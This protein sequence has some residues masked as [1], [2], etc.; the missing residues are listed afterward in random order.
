M[1]HLYGRFWTRADLSQ[2]VGQMEQIAGIRAL[3]SRDGT[4]RGVR[5]FE[6]FTGAGLT[7]RV[8]ADRALDISSCRF[9]DT[10]VAWSSPSG[11]VHPAYYEAD[12]LGWLRSFPGGLL[13]TCGLDH[14]GSPSSE[15]GE[16]FGIHGR[17]GNLPA[18]QVSYR[19]YWEGD[20]YI[21]EISG[22]VRQARLFGEFLTLQRRIRTQLGS[23]SIQ[24]DDEVIN[25]GFQSQ[26]HMILY[27]FNLGFPLISPQTELSIPAQETM[28]RDAEAESGFKDW[29]RLQPPTAGYREQVFRHTLNEGRVEIHN[30]ERNLRLTLTY[31]TATLP[32]LFQWKMMG[33]GAYVLGIE[34]ANSSAIQGRAK[35]RETGDLVILQP[36]ESCRYKLTVTLSA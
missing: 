25:E 18:R 26:P 28:A 7:F 36:G 5:V 14:F 11:E 13:A 30:P 31:D 32:H 19:A 8:M 16:S 6:V 12:G 17:I 20:D 2:Y 9:L 15:G 29:M 34:P 24:L 23:T 33:Q 22:E 4:E 1:A 27:H 21:L 10:P 3:E 35:A